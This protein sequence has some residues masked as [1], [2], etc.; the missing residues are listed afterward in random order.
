[1]KPASVEHLFVRANGVQLHVAMAGPTDGPLIILLHGFPEFW[2]GWR[3]QIEPLAAAGWRVCVPDQ[4]GYGQSDKPGNI[5]D[6][7]LDTLSDDVVAL[8]KVLGQGKFALVG[9]DWGGIVAWRTATR[10]PQLACLVVL[11][12]PHPGS[13]AAYAS[14]HPTQLIR[15]A[16][17]SFFQLPGLPELVLRT[18]GFRLLKR[19]LT[20]SSRKGT[21]PEDALRQYVRA[22]SQEGALTSMLNWYRALPFFV[23]AARDRIAAP[24][25]VIWGDRDSALGAGLAE[26][27]L[28]FCDEGEIVHVPNATH[29]VHHEEAG[30]VNA[31]LLRFTRHAFG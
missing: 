1:M 8:A 24:T 7:A 2:F 14:R 23:A 9:H 28:A 30:L 13:M 27:G 12:A 3:R 22:W 29:W 31:E 18:D 6:Y 4:R 5:R 11:N 10:H 20:T 19:A 15:I 26:E 21:F 16:Y 17:V 25:L